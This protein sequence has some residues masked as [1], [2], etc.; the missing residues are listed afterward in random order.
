MQKRGDDPLLVEM[1]LRR[2]DRHIDPAQGAVGSLGDE[3]LD[4]RDGLRIDRLPQYRE[5]TLRLARQ[6]FSHGPAPLATT[7]QQNCVVRV[8][9]VRRAMMSAPIR[10]RA[11]PTDGRSCAIA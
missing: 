2:K 8:P 10:L 9:R 6:R 4:C 11:T 7:R 3:L 1:L 5:Q